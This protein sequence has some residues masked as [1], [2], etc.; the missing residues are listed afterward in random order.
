M[1]FFFTLPILFIY[2][3][4]IFNNSRSVPVVWNIVE[5]TENQGFS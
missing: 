4:K 3:S 1:Y 2:D 5:E